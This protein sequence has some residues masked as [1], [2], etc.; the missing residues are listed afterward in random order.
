[1]THTEPGLIRVEADELTYDLHVMLRVEL[2]C[3]LMDGSL[4]VADLPRVWND[5][6]RRDLGVEVPNDA[7][8]VLQDIHWST[9]YVGSFPSYTIGNVTA[10]QLM[11]SLR[12][13][14]PDLDAA[15]ARGD[16]AVLADKLRTEVWQHGR[17]FTRDEMLTRTTGRP[18]EAGPYIAYLRG[19]YAT[20]N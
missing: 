10:A 12:R 13:D 8:G 17:R 6:I 9:G 3:A 2:E 20:G 18:L 11:D 19:K 5:T 4:D 15:V 7:K 1:V 14:D 16:Y